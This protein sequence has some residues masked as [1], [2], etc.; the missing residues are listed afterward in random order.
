MTA[1]ATIKI[2][3][4]ARQCSFNDDVRAGKIKSHLIYD[5]DVKIDGEFRAQFRPSVYRGYNLHDAHGFHVKCG[6]RNLWSR[7]SDVSAKAEFESKVRE[8]LGRDLIPTL[9]QLAESEA[10]R[11]RQREAAEAERHE[12]ERLEQIRAA[13]PKLLAA[14]QTVMAGLNARIDQASTNSEPIPVFD[15]I[16]ELHSAITLATESPAIKVD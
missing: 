5:F 14:A 13:A 7:R 3:R 1:A 8:C 9:A 15:G 2:E 11:Q 6:D 4:V 12:R 10:E 16:A